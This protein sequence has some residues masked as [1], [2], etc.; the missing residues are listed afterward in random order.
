MAHETIAAGRTVCPDREELT[1]FN[2]GQ[3]TSPRLEALAEHLSRCA[4]CESHLQALQEKDTV[5]GLLRQPATAVA[6][7]DEAACRQL[8]DRARAIPLGD[9]DAPT[10]SLRAGVDAGEGLPL[11]RTFGT[12]LLLKKLGQGGMGIV[13]QARQEMLKRLIALKVVLNGVFASDEERVRFRREG[14]ALARVRHANVVHIYELGECQGQLF[15]AMEWLE[16]GTLKERL[17]GRTLPEREAAQLLATLARAVQALHD[18]DIVHRDLKPGNILFAADGTPKIADFG[19]V[20][21]LDSAEVDTRSFVVLGTAAYMP[22]EQARGGSRDIGKATDVYA[23]GAILYQALTGRTPFQGDSALHTLELLREREVQPPSRHRPGL[24]RVLEAI[25]LK[26][27]QKE[28]DQRYL[29]G[30]AL[31]D[32]LDRWLNGEPTQVRPPSRAARIW[33]AVRRHPRWASAAVLLLLL[34]IV[35]PAGLWYRDPERHRR[36][37]EAE[38]ARGRAQTLIG[39]TS[40]P[41]WS[42]WCAGEATSQMSVL[43]DGSFSLNSWQTA[44][45]ELVRDP[46]RSHYRFSALVR[47]EQGV[48]Q[49]E[50]GIYVADHAQSLPAGVI[51]QFVALTFYDIE[52]DKD[53]WAKVVAQPLP[54]KPP[55]PKGNPVMLDPRLYAER[56]PVPWGPRLHCGPRDF[57]EPA[58]IGHKEWR[59]LAVEVTP[60]GVKGF[61]DGRAM[62]ILTAARM[63][64]VANDYLTEVRK[65]Q[66]EESLAQDCAVIY[67]P[68][69]GLGLYV[70]NGT[71][72]FRRVVIEPLDDPE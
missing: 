25:C 61:W 45:L 35:L 5:Q 49:A 33:H 29:S 22:P 28:P 47:Q 4:R 72:S 40:G 2:S 50:M 12:Y 52:R 10:V 36:A 15:Y 16:G 37:I 69:G 18:K 54:V 34:A 14:E 41:R 68:R 24:D 67:A 31:A 62:G 7:D 46:Q 38:L 44:R 70:Q 1:A 55:P 6:P 58:G 13:Y 26:C 32:E 71:A 65:R 11:P 42:S 51:H 64:G 66:P 48:R 8:E 3:L 53:L 9:A 59:K 27:L 21:L 57:F 63:M 56:A 23:L 30:A 17:N 20:K 43:A 39:D 60:E 19:L